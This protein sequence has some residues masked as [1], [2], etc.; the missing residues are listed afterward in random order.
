MQ[1]K[2]GFSLIELM[3]VIAIIATLAMVAIPSFMKYVAKAKRAEAYVQLSS[4]Y[5]AQK[6]YWTQHGKYSNKL[7][8]PGG[9]GW[10]PEGYQGGGANE[11]FNYTYG[12]PGSEGTNFFTGKL[13]TSSSHLGKGHAGDQTFVAIAAG[14][15][16]GKGKPDILG[17][18][19]YNNI[20]ILQDALE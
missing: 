12:F 14:D 16:T 18:D 5:A 17:V 9:I 1:K 7:S 13:G 6:I 3:V 10:M 20:T 8:G 19:Q 15:I 2:Y 11:N 4:L